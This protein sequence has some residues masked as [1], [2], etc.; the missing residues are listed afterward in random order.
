[1]RNIKLTICYDGSE[2]CG[3]QAQPGLPTIQG[4]LVQVVGK[5]TQENVQVFGAGRTDAGVHALG[6]VANFSTETGLSAADFMR[7]FNALLP[8]AIRVLRCEEVAPSFHARFQAIAKTYQYRISRGRVAPPF[9]RHYT[10]HDSFP[11]NI[12]AMVEAA[13]LFEG[14][15]DFSSFAAS[16]G[17]EETDQTRLLTREIY[18]SHFYFRVGGN[19]C[20]NGFLAMQSSSEAS[21]VM[22]SSDEACAMELENSELLY[23]VRGKS[24]LRNMV[25][26]IV[27]TL[28]EVGRGKL[29]PKDI[30]EIFEL[31]DRSKSGFTAPPQGLYLVS[32]EYPVTQDGLH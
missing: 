23:V 3:W 9:E 13:R 5:V 12:P 26:K 31:R 15:H 30:P 14:A 16:S 20:G 25:R 4:T 29:R 11:L 18:S 32:V 21:T 27:G 7:A 19:Y 1:M 22:T 17:N 2:F 6:Q 24:F 10:L 28:L 8:D